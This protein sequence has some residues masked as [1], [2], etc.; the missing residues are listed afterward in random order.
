MSSAALSP[1]LVQ[2]L[3]SGRSQFNARVAEACRAQPGFDTGLLQAFI[4]GPLDRLASQV[5]Q[6]DATRLNTVTLAA[7]EA[8]LTLQLR[9]KHSLPLVQALWDELLPACLPQLLA[10]PRATLGMLF[11][12]LLYLHAQ[13]GAR[14]AQWLADLRRLAAH[15]PDTASLRAL[16]QV[17]AWR[18]GAAHFRAS[19]LNV[20]AGLPAELGAAAF[21]LTAGQHWPNAL[22]RLQAAPWFDPAQPDRTGLRL[23]QVCGGFSGFGGPFAAPPTARVH[24]EGFVLHSAGRYSYLCAD[25]FGVALHAGSADE[26]AAGSPGTDELAV[27]GGRL[28]YGEA[29]CALPLPA[30]GLQ[31]VCGAQSA[32]LCSPYSHYLHLVALA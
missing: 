14:P 9:G 3:Q 28:V 26:Y 22:Q 18:C 13:A 8:A 7:F 32:L 16:G 12:G 19:A 6:Q 29:S 20:L 4:Q 30:E 25:A 10:E 5:A 11:N 27:R 21:Q 24:G 23:T 17:L 15:C 1:A 31:I 2:V